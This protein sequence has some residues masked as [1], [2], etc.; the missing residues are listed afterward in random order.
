MHGLPQQRN[1]YR[2]ML[3]LGL[4]NEED[5]NDDEEEDVEERLKQM[6]KTVMIV[7]IV[8]GSVSALLLM[9]ITCSWLR[10][11]HIHWYDPMSSQAQ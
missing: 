8:C 7:S 1:D 10:R 11:K 4:Y 9:F 2:N 3:G 5:D 6:S